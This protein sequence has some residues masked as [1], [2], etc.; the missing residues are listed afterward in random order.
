MT[1]EWNWEE[2]RRHLETQR[3]SLEQQAVLF[4]TLKQDHTYLSLPQTVGRSAVRWA[5]A[6]EQMEAAT[7]LMGKWRA[8]LDEVDAM[9]TRRQPDPYEAGG[10]LSDETVSLRGTDLPPPDR[11]PPGTLSIKHRYSLNR[12]RQDVELHLRAVRG[13]VTEVATIRDAARPVEDQW[14]LIVS[15]LNGQTLSGAAVVLRDRVDQVRADAV[16]D[17]LKLS[18]SALVSL[19]SEMVAF[20]H[21]LPS[22]K[23]ARDDADARF[24]AVEAAVD[25]L[26]AQESYAREMRAAVVERVPY[27]LRVLPSPGVAA[28]FRTRLDPLAARLRRD[29]WNVAGELAALAKE[30]EDA[31]DLATEVIKV[32]SRCVRDDCVGDDGVRDD[33]VRDDSPGGELDELGICPHC[34][35]AP[36]LDPLARW[37]RP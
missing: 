21:D 18:R 2:V 11:R 32:S 26:E 7:S 8:A 33:G 27:L 30:V 3:A 23:A 9:V 29:W 34:G 5:R 20:H 15:A 1:Q 35:R 22:S 14:H 4:G 37:E 24:A 19:H 28:E 12:L 10:K 16:A 17:P 13:L 36:T 25:V 31:V 6:S